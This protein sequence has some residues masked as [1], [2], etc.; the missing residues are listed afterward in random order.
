LFNDLIPL[1]GIAIATCI[2]AWL[3]KIS[4]LA[5]PFK[6]W[7]WFAVIAIGVL[8][9]LSIALPLWFGVSLT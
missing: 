4:P 2:I 1:V 6:S 9:A 5:E 7:L 3:V 8:W